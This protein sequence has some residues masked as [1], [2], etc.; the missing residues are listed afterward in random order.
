MNVGGPGGAYSKSNM[1]L[2]FVQG[3]EVKNMLDFMV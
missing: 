3:H 1:K 2:I